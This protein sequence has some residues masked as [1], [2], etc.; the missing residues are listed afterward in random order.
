[1]FTRDHERFVYL[2][3]Y[4]LK[5][6]LS[7]ALSRSLTAG[8]VLGSHAGPLRN[9]LFRLLDTAI[10]ASIQQVSGWFGLSI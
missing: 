7:L 8:N 2:C 6:H 5:T 1:M 3:L 4:L 10:P 9:L